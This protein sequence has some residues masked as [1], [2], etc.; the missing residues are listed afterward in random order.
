MM[1]NK[2]KNFKLILDFGA[3]FQLGFDKSSHSGILVSK[4]FEVYEKT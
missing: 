1:A 4:I 3:A 2:K